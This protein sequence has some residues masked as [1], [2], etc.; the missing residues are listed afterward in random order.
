MGENALRIGEIG[1]DFGAG[2]TTLIVHNEQGEQRIPCG[3]GT[4]Q[5]SR[6][7][8][9]RSTPPTPRR[10]AP[11]RS[12]E[13]RGEQCLDRRRPTREDLVAR[14]AVRAHAH[15]PLAG[16]SISVEWQPNAAFGPVDPAHLEGKIAQ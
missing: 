6:P 3:H 14:D 5:R 13:A 7:T 4:W 16:D 2:A 8:S 12:V 15:L 11:A 9:G 10:A 1:L